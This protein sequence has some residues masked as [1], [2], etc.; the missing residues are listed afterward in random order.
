MWNRW[1]MCNMRQR[2][3]EVVAMLRKCAEA[4]SE[5]AYLAAEQ[6]LTESSLWKDNA[7]LRT[8]FNNHWRDCKE[9]SILDRYCWAIPF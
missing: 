4:E 9:V 7:R 3:D 5:E 2:K 8:Y 6:E 1:L